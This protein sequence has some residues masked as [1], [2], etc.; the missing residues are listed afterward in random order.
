MLWPKLTEFCE[1][2]SRFDP[3]TT[4]KATICLLTCVIDSIS[5]ERNKTHLTLCKFL[6]RNLAQICFLYKIL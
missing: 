2:L 5:G 4:R 1:C 3:E 6:I